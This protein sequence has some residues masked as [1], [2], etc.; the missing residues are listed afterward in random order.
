M[1]ETMEETMARMQRREVSRSA[2]VS[3]EET[4]SGTMKRKKRSHSESF[5]YEI[6]KTMCADESSVT[7]E[8]KR[9]G[10]MCLSCDSDNKL[11]TQQATEEDEG[12]I[13]CVCDH[14]FERNEWLVK[15]NECDN[16]Q[17]CMQ[18]YE[19]MKAQKAGSKAKIEVI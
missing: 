14:V 10:N 15:C 6:K 18:C 9:D 7:I 19:Q 12:K 2:T 4:I 1:A 3:N 11:V 13:C 16:Y 5:G 8:M 17:D